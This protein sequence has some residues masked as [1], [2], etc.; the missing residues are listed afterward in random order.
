M[1]D[2]KRKVSPLLWDVNRKKRR[3]ELKAFHAPN[4]RCMSD[5]NQG[6]ARPHPH[7]LYDRPATNA[8]HGPVH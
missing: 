2:A 6:Y 7:K 3:S 5:I 1:W 8:F 4:S